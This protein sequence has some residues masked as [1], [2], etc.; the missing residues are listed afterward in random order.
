MKQLK[1]ILSLIILI[2]AAII[3]KA[4]TVDEIVSKH[5][6]A[7]GGADAWEKINSVRVEGTMTVQGTDVTIAVTTLHGKGHREDISLMGLSGYQ[8]IPPAGGWKYMPFQGQTKVEP[9]P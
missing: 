3:V 6:D 1:L 9:M 2:P 8:I 7:I 5:V 4:Q